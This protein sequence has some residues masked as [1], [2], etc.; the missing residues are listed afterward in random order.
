LGTALLQR[1]LISPCLPLRF[2]LITAVHPW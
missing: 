1:F 2:N